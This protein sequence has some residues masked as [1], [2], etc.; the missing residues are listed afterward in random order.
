[1]LSS[2]RALMQRFVI[3][4]IS[5]LEILQVLSRKL[6]DTE[7]LTLNQIEDHFPIKRSTI[8]VYL[9][10]HDHS[11]YSSNLINI[12]MQEKFGHRYSKVKIEEELNMVDILLPVIQALWEFFGKL[13]VTQDISFKIVIQKFNGQM[14]GVEKELRIVYHFFQ[15]L[16]YG[17]VT[18]ISER[19][20]TDCKHK[21]TSVLQTEECKEIADQI[22]LIRE[23]FKMTGDF[24]SLEQ[25]TI[26]VNSIENIIF[27]FP[28]KS[29]SFLRERRSK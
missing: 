18:T 29:L 12:F 5:I 28:S 7:Q 2:N 27:L 22:L 3:F 13:V 26:K 9:A 16:D 24:S 17:N 20:I 8:P 6:N 10:A 14:N 19:D 25:L 21:I 1:M 11:I 4:L 23:K 15:D